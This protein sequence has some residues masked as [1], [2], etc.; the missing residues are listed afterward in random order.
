MSLSTELRAASLP[1]SV[2]S[3]PRGARGLAVAPEVQDICELHDVESIAEAPKFSFDSSL[4]GMDEMGMLELIAACFTTG[5]LKGR[6]ITLVG[7]ADPR[8]A[9]SYNMTLGEK[10]ANAVF[11]VLIDLGLPLGSIAT[12]SRGKSDATGKDEE[13]WQ[14]DRRVDIDVVR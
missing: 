3:A 12:R 11:G 14:L 8:G 13:G 7:R 5:P 2:G 6:S 4:I 1:R 10:R 9:R